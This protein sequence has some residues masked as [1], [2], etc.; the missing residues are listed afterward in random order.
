[1]EGLFQESQERVLCL[2]RRFLLV[3]RKGLDVGDYWGRE[4]GPVNV[5]A[6]LTRAFPGVVKNASHWSS[7]LTL[8]HCF[9][10]APCRAGRQ[11]AAWPTVHVH[12]CVKE[13]SQCPSAIMICEPNADWWPHWDS[14]KHLLESSS[15]SQIHKK[16]WNE[17]ID[18]LP[19]LR[20]FLGVGLGDQA[21]GSPSAFQSTRC[22][23]YCTIL[24]LSNH[25]Y[26]CKSFSS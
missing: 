11:N 24:P 23:C 1:M 4:M 7:E 20:D 12:I 16:I 8:E 5:G 19:P 15:M 18:F 6:R 10:R 14:S 21:Q 13:P 22:P 2:S 25:E 26:H 17:N 3:W 9:V